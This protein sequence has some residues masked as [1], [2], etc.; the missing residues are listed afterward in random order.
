MSEFAFIQ[1]NIKLPTSNFKINP[2]NS[3]IRTSN[4]KLQE[5]SSSFTLL[6]RKPR[7][8]RPWVN[9]RRVP[10]EALK[11]RSRVCFGGFR[12][13]KHVEEPWALARGAPH[14]DFA[15][16]FWILRFDVWISA[17]IGSFLRRIVGDGHLLIFKPRAI[18]CFISQSMAEPMVVISMGVIRSKMRAAALLPGQGSFHNHLS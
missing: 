10:F 18:I 13:T 16:S 2:K 5:I 7:V 14:N 1:S 9:A 11:E 6:R 4:L 15:S 8:F 3:E 17:L 12:P